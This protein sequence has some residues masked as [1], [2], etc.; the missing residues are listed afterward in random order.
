MRKL[1]VLEEAQLGPVDRWA[2]EPL[3]DPW[4]EDPLVDR[5][6]ESWVV[7]WYLSGVGDRSV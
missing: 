6:A 2:Q 5:L 1:E 7:Q 4:V 3:G